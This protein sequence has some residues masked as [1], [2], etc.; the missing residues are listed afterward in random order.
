MKVAVVGAG[1]GGLAAAIELAA[2]GHEVT[3]FERAATPGGKCG[4]VERGGFVW[5]A[6]PSLLT[7][8][9]GVRA[10]WRRSTWSGWSP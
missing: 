3:V 10:T 1:V 5:D 2:P 8:A 4:R 9:V 7:H 6:G